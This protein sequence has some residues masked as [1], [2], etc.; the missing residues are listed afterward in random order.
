MIGLVLRRAAAQLPLLAAV[1][2]VVTIGATLL[3]VCALLVTATQQRALNAELARAG[4]AAV[5]VT[6]FMGGV[7]AGA[8]GPVAAAARAVVTGAVAPL[9]AT[10]STRAS[11]AL[12]TLGPQREGARRLAYLAAVDGLPGRGRLVAGRWPVAGAPVAE[13]AVL[14]TTADVL[15]LAPGRTV[16]LGPA[17]AAP[18]TVTVR[19]VGVF[20]PLPD[21]GWDRDPLRAAG[22][23]PQFRDP[24]PATAYGPFLV[25]LADLLAGGWALDRLQVTAHPAVNAAQVGAAV[26]S[27][28][29]DNGR[30]TAA[31][32][33]RVQLDRVASELPA[34]LAAARSQQAVTRST[35][36]VVV[37]L[38]TA[39]TATVL[40]L[41]GRLVAGLRSPESALLASY[42]AGRRQLV[43]LAGVEAGLLAAV[44]AVLAVPL[45]GVLHSVLTH[46]PGPAAAGLAAPPRGDGG[47]GGGGGGRGGG[48]GR[49]A[50]AAGAAPAV[51]CGRPAGRRGRPVAAGPVVRGPGAGR[52]GRGR[53]VA[54][55]RAAGHGDRPGRGP[56][57]GAGAGPGGRGGAGAAAGRCRWRWPSG[58]PGGPGRWCCRWPRSRRPGGRGWWRRRCCSRW[59]RRPARSGWPSGRPGNARS[60]TRPTC[61]SA[62][63]WP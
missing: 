14:T 16:R 29:G 9:P 61:G 13:A 27:L 12:R 18:G 60:G 47:P 15:G 46:R 20:R 41:A 36:L 24:V 39:L 6:A 49:G 30:L 11:A 4:P 57:A 37:L 40:G 48:A 58:A 54:A 38:G 7:R 10:T 43:A 42:G 51:H 34:T 45:S 21:A 31:L 25:D 8:G 56:G 26:A 33:D 28:S 35:V 44:A 5:D 2:A 32:G 55:G 50:G 52:A 62:P 22:Y 63:T 59:P 23:D 53:V 1:L 19:V 17:P 3:G